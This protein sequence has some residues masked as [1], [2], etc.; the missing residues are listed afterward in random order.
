[1]RPSRFSDPDIL[2]ALRRVT[3]GVPAVQ[4][5]R[6]LG[7]TQTTFYRWRARLDGD[8]INGQRELRLLR[9]ENEKLRRIVTELL[10][11]NE[12]NGSVRRLR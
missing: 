6:E 4:V 2:A 12:A 1:M 5:C 7:I 9:T 8:A 3:S 10:L 11:K